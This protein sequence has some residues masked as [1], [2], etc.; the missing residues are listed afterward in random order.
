[1]DG[2]MPHV[3]VD[4]TLEFMERSSIIFAITSITAEES[5]YHQPLENEKEYFQACNDYQMNLVK[6][7]P[8]KFG[9]FLNFPLSTTDAAIESIRDLDTRYSDLPVDGFLLPAEFKGLFFGDEHFI[10]IYEELNKRDNVVIFTHP[11]ARMHTLKGQSSTISPCVLEFM[12]MTART[13]TTLLLNEVFK[14]F[15]NIKWIFPHLGNNQKI[16]FELLLIPYI[17]LL[18]CFCTPFFFFHCILYILGGCFPYIAYRFEMTGSCDDDIF[19]EL[20]KY[21]NVYFDAAGSLSTL[22]WEGTR[23]KPE[24]ILAGS[25]APYQHIPYRKTTRWMSEY[26]IDIVRNMHNVCYENAFTL[27]PRLKAKFESNVPNFSK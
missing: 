21:K 1:M 11:T 24:Q 9:A 13:I 27:F 4:T 2:K 20:W 6:E 18:F 15:P 3:S 5:S 26:N 10:P 14:R 23:I 25:D 19:E 16:T 12:V 22:Q 7:Y 8:D 17:D